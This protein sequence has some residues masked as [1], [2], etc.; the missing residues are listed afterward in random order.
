VFVGT[1]VQLCS[2]GV[3]TLSFALLG[4]LSP[5]NRGSLITAF[6]LLFVFMGSFAGYYSSSTYKMFRGILWKQNTLMTAFF[7]PGVVF[8]VIFG[9]NLLLWL[10]GSSGA[11]PFP[12]LFT[13]LF[14]WFC[15]S[16]PLVFLGSFFGYKRYEYRLCCAVLLRAHP[17]CT[18]PYLPCS[19]LI[20]AAAVPWHIGKSRRSPCARTRSPA[21][22]PRSSGT[23]TP[24]CPACWAASCLSAR[25]PWSST[26]SCPPSGCTR[27]GTI[28]YCGGIL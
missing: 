18:C 17:H 22:S 6:I 20:Y 4:L 3:A 1:G 16:V 26:S 10:K 8:S 23:C 12:S 25:C 14:L 27:Y 13:L 21:P 24:R 5:A 15:V 19:L 2:M 9:L 11:I 7:Y 28:L